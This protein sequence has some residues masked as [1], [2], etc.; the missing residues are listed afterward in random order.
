[1]TKRILVGDAPGGVFDP[2]HWH[3]Q[4]DLVAQDVDPPNAVQARFLREA[5]IPFMLQLE[6]EIDNGTCSHCITTGIERFIQAIIINYCAQIEPLS[7][8]DKIKFLMCENIRKH[9]NE[10]R[11]VEATDTDRGDAPLQ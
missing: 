4:I 2:D 11:L 8:G 10:L 7:D 6:K 9:C 1:M 5:L 3:R